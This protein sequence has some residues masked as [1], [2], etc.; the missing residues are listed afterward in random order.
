MKRVIDGK[1]YDTETA[2]L[3]V[4]WD[5]GC[6]GND[7]KSCSED[8]YITKNG[9]WFLFGS[10]G[11]MSKYATS[12]GNMMSS[13]DCIIPLTKQEAY[14]WLEKNNFVKELEEYFAECLVDA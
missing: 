3:V 12:A 1:R 14:D 4:S 5:N 8:L 6:Y 9:S 7:F 2:K 11:P 10:G 13:G